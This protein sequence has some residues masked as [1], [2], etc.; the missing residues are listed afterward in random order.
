VTGDQI[1]VVLVDDHPVVRDGL[2]ASLGSVD[3]FCVVG[4][5][6]SGQEALEVAIATHP[7]VVLMDLDMPGMGGQEAIRILTEHLPDI[8]VLVLTMY[9]D[10]DLVLGAIRAGARGYLLKGA[11][12]ADVVRS[13]TAVARGDA[14]FGGSVADRLLHVVT[15]PGATT[16]PFP[17]LTTREHD[18]LELLADGYSNPAMA[19]RLGLSSRTVANHVSSILAKLGLG[20]RAQAAVAGRRAGLGSTGRPRNGTS[21]APPRWVR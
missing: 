9:D 19:R 16:S 14:V 5:A 12:Q 3:G 2:K 13:I 4:E 11:P 8:A 20:D 15:A 1:T 21:E 6:G 18:V 10:I 17:Q 7:D